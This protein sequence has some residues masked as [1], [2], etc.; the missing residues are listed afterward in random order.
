[1]VEAITAPEFRHIMTEEPDVPLLDTRPVADY[2]AWHI[3]GAISFRFAPGDT[4]DAAALDAVVPDDAERILT[5]CGM[6]ISSFEF[7]DAVE[8]LG[9]PSVLVLRDGMVAWSRL[10]D[11]TELDIGSGVRCW[12]LQRLAKG[13]LGYVIACPR[14]DQAIAID[15]PVHLEEVT[16]LLDRVGLTLTGVID[17]HVHADHV[18]GGPALANRYDVPYYIGDR[19]ADRGFAYDHEPMVDGATITVG[20]I[21]LHARSTPG[22][23]SEM[24]SIIVGE[25]RA[26]LT[27]DT[28]FLDSVGR[29]ELEAADEAVAGARQLYRS[30]TK[31]LFSLPDDV[32][33]LPGHYDPATDRVHPPSTPMTATI[34]AIR[35]SID[36]LEAD[37]A[38]FVD[39]VVSRVG[40]RPPNY[41]AILLVNLGG[42]PRPAREIVTQLELGP[43]RCAATS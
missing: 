6:G 19:A 16:A 1:M 22:H 23:T 21:D 29:T 31:T 41:R 28:L 42:R 27:A 10:Y 33:V 26:V 13:C 4:L 43:N 12:Q 25:K 34:G 2:E 3:P 5:V 20:D 32:V 24:M 17:T 40:D 15:P 30:I 37:E 35:S 8:D 11:C 39:E 36:L 14:T 38:M 18:S 9:F 7:A